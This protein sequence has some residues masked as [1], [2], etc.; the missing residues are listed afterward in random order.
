[1]AQLLWKQPLLTATISKVTLGDVL[2]R[3]E[4]T[5]VESLAHEC[6]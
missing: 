1:M 5:G 2:Y 4:G 3:T 6:L